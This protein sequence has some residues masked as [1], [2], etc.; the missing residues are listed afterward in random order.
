MK[1]LGAGTLVPQKNEHNSWTKVQA[2]ELK[3]EHNSWT[4]VQAPNNRKFLNLPHIDMI[5][6]YQ[7][8]TFRTFDSIDDFL[9]RLSQEDIK[10]NKK[11]YKIDS[12]LDNSSN[13]CH[14]NGDILDYLKSFFLEKDK[15]I[16]E[17]IA[18][19]IMP[20]HI[21]ILFKQ[22]MALDKTMKILKGSSSN[23]INKLLEK[24][25]KFWEN[26]YYDKAIRDKKH[27]ITTYEYIKNNPLKVGLDMSRFYG[28]YE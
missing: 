1:D 17:L 9:K 10:S 5:G 14:L 8:V 12:Y 6:Y 19:C 4:K 21:H 7:F 13:G 22:N 16:Y 15:D 2:P 26:G 23:A 24:R 18:F 11:Q 20:N 27:F 3:S 25:G 28:A